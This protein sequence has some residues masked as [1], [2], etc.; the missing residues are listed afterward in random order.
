MHFKSRPRSPE[1]GRSPQKLYWD[2]NILLAEKEKIFSRTWQVVGHGSQVAN[3]GDY[4]TTDL[5]GEPLLFVRGS[6][7][8]LRGF[9]KRLPAPGRASGR[10]VR[11]A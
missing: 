8:K 10:G 4:F 1:P 6:D 11:L 3:P 5:M 7:A 2:T 9:Y